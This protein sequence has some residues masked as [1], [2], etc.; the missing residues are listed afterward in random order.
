MPAVPIPSQLCPP[1]LAPPVPCPPDL[2]KIIQLGITFADET[3]E[4]APDCPT[5]QF[6]F[7]FNLQA[8]LLGSMRDALPAAQLPLHHCCCRCSCC[9]VCACCCAAGGHVR[10]GLHRA[11]AAVGHRLRPA[12]RARHRRRGV[13]RTLHLVGP[14]AQRLRDVGVVPLGLRLRVP[15][16][17]AHGEPPALCVVEGGGEERGEGTGRQYGLHH[18][19]PSLLS[20]PFSVSPSP[21][22]EEGGFFDTLRTYFPRIYDIKALM[23]ACDA[24]KGGLN[25]LAEDLDVERVGPMHQAGSDSLLTSA[26]FFKLR[27]VYFEGGHAVAGDG[28]VMTSVEPFLGELFGLGS[29]GAAVA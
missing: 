17:A 27:R 29:G 7:R 1:L 19:P 8:R 23:S 3:G 20:P 28:K 9:C 5:W 26:A 12:R 11:A 21:S 16:Q 15:R 2:L 25:K 24:L 6:N 4:L 10:A 22:A 14:R 13:R 18:R